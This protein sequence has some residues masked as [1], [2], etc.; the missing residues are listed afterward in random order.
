MC[1]TSS[2]PRIASDTQVIAISSGIPYRVFGQQK[3][4]QMVLHAK[5]IDIVKNG[6]TIRRRI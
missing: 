2:E 5:T 4:L 1:K 6:V 3:T